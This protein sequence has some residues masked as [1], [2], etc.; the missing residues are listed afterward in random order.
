MTLLYVAAGLCLFTLAVHGL[1]GQQ[2]VVAPLLRGGVEPFARAT[3]VAVWHMITWTLAAASAALLFAAFTVPAYAFGVGL[4]CLGYALI[5]AWVGQRSFGSAIRLPQWILLGA[6]GVFALAGSTANPGISKGTLA[7]VLG[8]LG[9]VH[10]LW[11]LGVAW[12]SR[13]AQSLAMAVIGRK[14]GPSALAC[15]V[16]AFGLCAAGALLVL[17]APRAVRS[18]IAGAFVLRGTLGFV[19]PSFRGEIR[20]TPYLVYSRYMYT[21]LSLALGVAIASTV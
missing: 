16:A 20:G 7:G 2:R 18:C 11:A 10:A 13:D 14:Q 5:F 15:W 1:V 9:F 17:P 12:P 3:L 4:L 6:V 8:V 21:P 19:E